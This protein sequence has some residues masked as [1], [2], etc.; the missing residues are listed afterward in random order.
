MTTAFRRMTYVVQRKDKGPF[1]ISKDN[2]TPPVFSVACRSTDEAEGFVL[3]LPNNDPRDYT[4]TPV[5]VKL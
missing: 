2:T 5:R 3:H 1:R 4:C